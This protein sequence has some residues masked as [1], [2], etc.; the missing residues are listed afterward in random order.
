[1]LPMIRMAVGSSRTHAL[2]CPPGVLGSLVVFACVAAFSAEAGAQP[3]D[4]FVNRI[5]L[6]GATA[7]DTGSNVGFTGETGEPLPTASW[8]PL[9]TAWWSWTA[10]ASGSVI[11]DTNGSAF[12]TTLG[13]YTGTAVGALTL[14]VSDDDSGVGTQSLVTFA[15]TAGRCTK[16]PWTGMGQRRGRSR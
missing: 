1:M 8:A 6:T 12:D 4:D 2:G 13:V 7:S 16:S 9:E 10:P 14:V 11:I 3:N 15:A 5:A